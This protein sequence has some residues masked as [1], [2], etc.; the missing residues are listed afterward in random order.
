MIDFQTNSEQIEELKTAALMI[1]IS[2]FTLLGLL[3]GCGRTDHT[4]VDVLENNYFD[5]RNS[6]FPCLL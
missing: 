3:V 4:L 1:G 6:T 5:C 2:I